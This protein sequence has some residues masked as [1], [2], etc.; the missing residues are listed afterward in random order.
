M[1]A[2]EALVTA[3]KAALASLAGVG[4]YDGLPG[5]GIG[6]LGRDRGRTRD[7]LEQQE[8]RRPRIADGR[9]SERQG[10]TPARL[11]RLMGGDRRDI[12]GPGGRGGGRVVMPTNMHV[13]AGK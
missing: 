4:V 10:E 8:R 13:G 9:R 11:R 12:A 7:G 1:T 3:A 6:S 2:Q 5:A